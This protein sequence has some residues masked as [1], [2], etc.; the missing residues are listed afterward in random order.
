MSDVYEEAYHHFVW[1]T[2][3]REEMVLPRFESLLHG[4]VR[5]KCREMG[6]FVYAINGMP[7]HLHLV[8]AIPGT[9]AVSDFMNGVKGGSSYYISHLSQGESLR[10]QPGYGHLTFATNDLARVTAY[11]GNQKIHHS[12][13]SLSPKMERTSSG[14][15]GLSPISPA[16]QGRVT[17]RR[18]IYRVSPRFI[19]TRP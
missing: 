8:C 6:A 7:D 9:L 5:Q 16:L 12:G 4:Y 3:M 2:K 10:W 1:A 18:T 13:G 11:V 17:E 14:P 15:E 19:A